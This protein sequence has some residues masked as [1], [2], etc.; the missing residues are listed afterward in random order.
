MP[1]YEDDLPAIH[2]ELEA[3]TELN[4][5]YLDAA[6]FR[7]RTLT[8]IEIDE[9]NA[10]ITLTD[11]KGRRYLMSHHQDCC[12]LVQIHDLSGDFEAIL[13]RPLTIA[14]E[15]TSNTHPPDV[16][17][18][19]YESFTWTVY[20]FGNAD[21]LLRIRWF[22]TSNGYYSESVQIDRIPEPAPNYG[23]PL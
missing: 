20:E 2:A 21:A 9:A 1:D 11:S 6:A 16:P 14:R 22:G 8:D 12:E 5:H 18:D 3:E 17:G 19:S 23:Q 15:E 13:N 7:G 10:E 4:G